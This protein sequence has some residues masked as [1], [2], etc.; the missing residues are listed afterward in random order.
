[1]IIYLAGIYSRPNIFEKG[2]FELYSRSDHELPFDVWLEKVKIYLATPHESSPARWE[3]RMKLYLST[4]HGFQKH[5]T[6]DD[7]K[8]MNIYLA[9]MNAGNHPVWIEN[10]DHPE[11]AAEVFDL[12]PKI[13]ILESFVY[14]KDW[15][16]VYIEKY[17][18]FMI[19]SGAFTFMQNNSKSSIDWD[20]YVRRYAAFINEHKI[21]L[22]FELDIDS[23]AGIN[24]VERLREL[25]ESLTGKQ[26]IPVW[27]VRRGKDYWKRMIRDYKYV[28]IGG[29]VSGEITRTQYPGFTG[30]LNMAKDAG[31]KVHGLGFT[32][33]KGLVKYPFD[34]VDSTAWVYGNRGGFL[35]RFNGRTM[36]KFQIPSGNRLKAKEA[37]IFN[38]NEWIKFQRW[39]ENNL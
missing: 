36:E 20:E 4:P 3:E 1:M 30:L 14:Y 28:A 31:S 5:M 9:G 12:D 35:N 25:L 16:K 17:W 29:I 21:D 10:K 23:V 13:Y 24:E 11:R 2:M 22:F 34:S 37:A 6:G 33:L 38:F 26:S 39:A 19:D 8:D 18:H 32:N 27:H 15:M 7:P